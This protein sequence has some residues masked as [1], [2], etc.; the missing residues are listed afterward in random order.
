M[1]RIIISICLI[2]CMLFTMTACAERTEYTPQQEDFEFS[3]TLEKTEFV[4]GEE[5]EFT[6]TLIRK[7]GARFKFQSCS[8]LWSR[9][10]EPVG[11]DEKPYFGWP[12]DI[13]T[14]TIPKK[15]KYE[16]SWSILTE[17]YEPGD[18][19]LAVRFKMASLQYNFE[20]VITITE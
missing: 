5:L 16:M 4:R 1:K 13:V 18:Y 8:S 19:L 14:H 7:S 17:F 10:F 9:Y 20:Q 6:V 11:R 3:V 2:F 12:E 15:Y